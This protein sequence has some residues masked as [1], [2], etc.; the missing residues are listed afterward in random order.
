LIWVNPANFLCAS[1]ALDRE[2]HGKRPSEGPPSD[3]GSGGHALQ[4]AEGGDFFGCGKS[5]FK[6]VCDLDLEGIIAKRLDG[7]YDP[8]RTKWRKILNPTYSQKEGRS[9]LFERRYG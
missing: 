6:A 1:L 4:N 7:P 8:E 5:L 2:R 3:P 9:E